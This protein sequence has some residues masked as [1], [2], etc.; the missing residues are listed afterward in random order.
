MAYESSIDALLAEAG[1]T[2]TTPFDSV[3]DA[4]TVAGTGVAGPYESVVDAVIGLRTSVGVGEQ[5][6]VAIYSESMA[7]TVAEGDPFAD[8]FYSPWTHDV[9]IVASGF[10]YDDEGG[11]GNDE[12]RFTAANGGN[13]MVD[14]THNLGINANNTWQPFISIDGVK[15]YEY[16]EM[17]LSAL[18][19]G[20]RRFGLVATL[21]GGEWFRY[22]YDPT[23]SAEAKEGT[24]MSIIEVPDISGSPDI[25]RVCTVLNDTYGPVDWAEFNPWAASIATLAPITPNGFA[26]VG[27]TGRW[28]IDRDCEALLSLTLNI[29]STAFIVAPFHIKVNGVAI[30]DFDTGVS[31]SHFSPKVNSVNVPLTLSSGDYI[32][33]TVE[34]ARFHATS[35]LP[36]T[37]VS[38][39]Q[40]QDS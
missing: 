28:T 10:V 1:V 30:H 4:C 11:V 13:F 15:I 40:I 8:A 16:G 38:L 7:S 18:M 29:G 2:Q 5:D 31:G 3:A 39:I 33:V 35:L 22:T 12:G 25:A 20:S 23:N 14:A 32:E 36:G 19:D 26:Y 37:V 21:A 34:P 24:C 9:P 6:R 27:T 17:S